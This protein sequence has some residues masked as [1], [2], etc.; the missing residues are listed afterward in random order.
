M[1]IEQ[2]SRRCGREAGKA[3][4]ELFFPYFCGDFPSGAVD[5]GVL[6]LDFHL[7]DCI[8]TFPIGHVGVS[9]EC[10]EAFLKGLEAALDL[11][12]GLWAGG[13]D[14]GYVECL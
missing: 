12:F 14:V 3:F 8:G 11:A 2:C 10:D 9:E 1:Q 6:S 7:K 4:V 13:H 5:D